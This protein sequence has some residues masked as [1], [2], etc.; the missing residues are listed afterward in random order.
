MHQSEI[1]RYY[2]ETEIDYRLVW[3]LKK[4]LAMHLGYWD[5]TVSNLSQSLAREN[6]VLSQIAKIKKFETVL[7]AGC[8]VGGT[9]IFLAKSFNCKVT[10]IALGENQVIESRENAKRLGVQNLTSFFQ[11]DFE[12]MDFE[13]TFDVVL[14]IES[15]CHARSKK[16][17]VKNAFRALKSGGRLLIADGFVVKDHY[18]QTEEMQNWL[19][20]WGVDSLETAE[21][22][23]NFAQEVGFSS[24]FFTDV[25]N[26][27]IPSSKRLYKLSFPASFLGKIAKF[28]RVRTE[29]QNKNIIAARYQYIALMQKLWQYGFFLAIK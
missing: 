8:G 19:S 10:G 29:V 24:V 17:F 14:A 27:V 1:V 7:D 26:N 18:N 28:I 4:S 22:F 5:E 12:R 2:D 15:A 16:T 25:T 20:G 3:N 6:Q 9:A 21:N 23:K 11:M 13:S